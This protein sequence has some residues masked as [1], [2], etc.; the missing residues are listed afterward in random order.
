M[1]ILRRYSFVDILGVIWLPPITAAQRRELDSY[2][3]D[4]MTDD[5]GTITR[6]SL[7]HWLCLHS[8][9]FQS[10]TDFSASIELGDDTIDIPWSNEDNELTYIDCMP[11]EEPPEPSAI[12]CLARSRQK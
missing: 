12:I 4:N 9:D 5:N 7:E 1:K 6:D 3:I 10:I 8:G 11:G 2:D